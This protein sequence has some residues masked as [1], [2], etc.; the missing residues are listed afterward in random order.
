MLAE[1]LQPQADSNGCGKYTLHGRRGSRVRVRQR[2]LQKRRKSALSLSRRLASSR[3]WPRYG[4]LYGAFRSKSC[5]SAEGGCVAR[6]ED[7]SD[8]DKDDDRGRVRDRGSD[9]NDRSLT[10]AELQKFP[11]LAWPALLQPVHSPLEQPR[12]RDG[13]HDRCRTPEQTLK[14]AGQEREHW[15]A[16]S[17]AQER[18]SRWG[19]VRE[20]LYMV[21]RGPRAHAAQPEPR[22]RSR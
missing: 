9:E 19:P 8:D 17:P 7:G 21:K 2:V 4:T 12:E 11:L 10:S 5:G 15:H 6:D 13:N 1:C 16:S 18:R 22:E 14:A 20:Q 3:T